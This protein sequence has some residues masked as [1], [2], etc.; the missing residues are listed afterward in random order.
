MRSF[1]TVT[2]I[3]MLGCEHAVTDHGNTLHSDRVIE[4][5]V[6]YD[7]RRETE[8]AQ[9]LLDIPSLSVV[10]SGTS[11]RR[12]QVFD[13]LSLIASRTTDFQ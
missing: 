8:G 9:R 13:D 10:P 6:D 1:A 2:L 7:I 11:R 5:L 12:D 3:F 4:Q